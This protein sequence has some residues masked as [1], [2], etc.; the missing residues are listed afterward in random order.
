M[1]EPVAKRNESRSANGH[2]ITL[3]C[4]LSIKPCGPR[5]GQSPEPRTALSNRFDILLLQAFLV[6]NFS[7]PFR[8]IAVLAGNEDRQLRRTSLVVFLFA[9]TPLM[10]P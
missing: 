5:R 2:W 10:T 8:A 9:L 4:S 3:I 7:A 1:P 6:K